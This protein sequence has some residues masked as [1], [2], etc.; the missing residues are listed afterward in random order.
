M[1]PG[2]PAIR[3]RRCRTSRGR[4]AR[5]ALLLGVAAGLLAAGPAAASS[6]PTPGAPGIGDKLY[7]TLGNG[8][9]DALHYDVDLRYATSDPAQPLDGTVTILARATQ[10]LSRF[11]LD[12]GGTGVG[13][14]V[15]R[16]PA[17]RAGAAPAT[18]S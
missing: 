12:F 17:R 18:S 16:R 13:E 8:G 7:P 3:S 6:A 10:A 11:D 5:L 9:Y 2:A 14:R 15:G 1:S 4:G